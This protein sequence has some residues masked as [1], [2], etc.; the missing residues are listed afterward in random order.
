M[1][2]III[3]GSREFNNY[4]KVLESFSQ[5]LLY[6][7]DKDYLI[8]RDN[9]EIISGGAGGADALGEKLARNHEIPLKIFPAEWDNFDVDACEIR[10]NRYGKPYNV[11]A[12]LNRNVEMAKYAQ[13]SSLGILMAFWDG[14]SHGTKHMINAARKH[15]LL[16]KI[17]K[18]EERWF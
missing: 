13:D 7:R 5:L 10:Y 1:I 14:K 15:E 8:S 9:L 17:Y 3:A 12:G 4:S 2:K 18:V 16:V 11:L 6:L